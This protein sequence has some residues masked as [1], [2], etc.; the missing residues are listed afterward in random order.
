MAYER[1]YDRKPK[2][3]EKHRLERIWAHLVDGYGE[4]GAQA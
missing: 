3:G 4:E 2:T 1:Y